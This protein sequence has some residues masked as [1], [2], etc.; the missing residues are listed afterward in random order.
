MCIRDRAYL[1]P[2][3]FLASLSQSVREVHLDAFLFGEKVHGDYV[4]F[5]EESG[6][7]SITQYELYQA[8]WSSLND[9]NLF[10]LA[11]EMC[12]RDSR[13]PLPDRPAPG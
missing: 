13:R 8:I 1:I 9:A 12:I 10:E 5:V 4:R 2:E 11:W 3:A 6:L 7:H